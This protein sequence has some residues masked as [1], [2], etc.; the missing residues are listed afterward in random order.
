MLEANL[1]A[2][3]ATAGKL[4]ADRYAREREVSLGL[5]LRPNATRHA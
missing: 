1:G 2:A 3:A 4:G 5:S